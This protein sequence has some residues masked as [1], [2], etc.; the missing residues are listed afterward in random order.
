[1]VNN[2][3]TE[4]YTVQDDYYS[5]FEKIKTGFKTSLIN[6]NTGNIIR[7]YPLAYHVYGG[8]GGLCFVESVTKSGIFTVSIDGAI[9]LQRKQYGWTNKTSVQCTKEELPQILAVLLGSKQKVEFSSHGPENNK[10]FSF[11][12][13]GEKVFVR[14]FEKGKPVINVP[15]MAADCFYVSGIFI[16]QIH[17]NM[18]WLSSGQDIF[19]LI[20]RTIR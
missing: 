15:I 10:G 18:P 6:K 19:S 7:E 3:Y 14:M 5:E 11:E 9:S 1:M 20:D 4:N 13:Q 8:K 2:T 16:K 17:A 12:H